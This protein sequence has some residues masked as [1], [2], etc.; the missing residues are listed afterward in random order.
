MSADIN[1]TTIKLIIPVKTFQ[2]QS[3]NGYGL[4]SSQN[5]SDVNKSIPNLNNCDVE[6]PSSTH[7][8]H[9]SLPPPLQL[10]HIDQPLATSTLPQVSLSDTAPP[11]PSPESDGVNT[12]TLLSQCIT[13]ARHHTDTNPNLI[14]LTD[15]AHITTLPH[16]PD[17]EIRPNSPNDNI[18]WKESNVLTNEVIEQINVAYDEIVFFRQN[19]F[20]FHPGQSQKSI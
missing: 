5:V 2:R 4:R 16:L 19:L 6:P 10:P 17:I 15:R 7:P 18:V 8:T 1:P 9:L 12:P 14:T 13:N 3:S 20:L 11:L